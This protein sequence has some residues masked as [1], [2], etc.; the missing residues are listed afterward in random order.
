MWS[1]ACF[2][3]H[4]CPGSSAHLKQ[5]HTPQRASTSNAVVNTWSSNPQYVVQNGNVNSFSRRP[6]EFLLFPMLTILM[7]LTCS[8]SHF[9]NWW[10]Y[11]I[12]L[13]TL[14][15]G[16]PWVIGLPPNQNSLPCAG[17]STPQPAPQPPTAPALCPPASGPL[18]SAQC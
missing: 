12:L 7:P 1:L 2:C 3:A 17:L 18:G 9:F 8:F 14:N 6:Q 16:A 15:V 13:Q 5:G 11:L 4:L 10:P